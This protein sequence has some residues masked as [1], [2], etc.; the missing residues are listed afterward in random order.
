MK[1][2]N[3]GLREGFFAGL[4]FGIWAI[5][6]AKKK[7]SEDDFLASIVGA[8]AQLSLAIVALSLLM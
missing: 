5:F 1:K 8:S 2:E 3:S 7:W 4:L 6:Y